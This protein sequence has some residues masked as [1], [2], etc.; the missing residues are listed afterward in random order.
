[1]TSLA[2]PLAVLL[3][4]WCIG[5]QSSAAPV[6]N[7]A[8]LEQQFT[9]GLTK[10]GVDGMNGESAIAALAEA[11]GEKSDAAGATAEPGIGYER[12]CRSV[13]VVGSVD[14]CR[15][16]KK[17]HMGAVSS[18]WVVDPRGRIVTNYHVLED[19]G[20]EELGVM[21]FDGRVYPV[22]AVVAADREGDAAIVEVDTGGAALP[23]LPVAAGAKT[24]E[25]IIVVGH[26]DG[27]FYTLT[28]GIVSRVF[29][30][31]TS[32]GKGR[33]NWLTVTA[34]YGVGSSGAPVLNEAGEVVGMVS[35]TATLLADAGEGEQPQAADVQMV[36]RD[37]VSVNTMRC[38][39][40]D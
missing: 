15:D 5:P 37:C 33:R 35:S 40:A 34:D 14:F 27:R 38:L 22:R 12:I 23:A 28:E 17:S 30:Q 6:I 26:P 24:G 29:S 21:T 10:A 8:E 31:E 11:E 16:C 18:G 1:M 9:S 25:R 7:D 13:V 19:K 3:F 2:R 32:D 20:A 4:F 36:F 39:I